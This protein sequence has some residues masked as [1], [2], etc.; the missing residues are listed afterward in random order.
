MPKP[1]RGPFLGKAGNGSNDNAK[2]E[3]RWQLHE[4]TVVSISDR[5]RLLQESNLQLVLMEGR[6]PH[7]HPLDED[8]EEMREVWEYALNF[9]ELGAEPPE[10]AT[11]YEGIIC[12]VGT[13][14]DEKRCK[15][16]GRGY[17]GRDNP[18]GDVEG[19]FYRPPRIEIID[20]DEDMMEPD[21]DW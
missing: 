14:D 17:V 1:I 20:A 6:V 13:T 8:V 3:S 10:Q 21:L 5:G 7:W 18:E 12:I 2:L 9:Y 4:A 11:Q 19:I 16:H 15:I